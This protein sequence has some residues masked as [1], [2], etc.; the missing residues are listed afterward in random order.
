M[1]HITG[2]QPWLKTSLVNG[3]LAAMYIH[4]GV[5]NIHKIIILGA[6]HGSLPTNKFIFDSLLNVEIKCKIFSLPIELYKRE[7]IQ[8]KRASVTKSPND[9]AIGVATLSGLM[10]IRLEHSI[11]KTMT[12]PS[13][14]LAIDAVTNEL[15]HKSKP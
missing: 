14:K 13:R 11:T 6:I 8:D 1:A 7:A 15:A 10:F 4:K 2:D 3:F 9:A 12:I 5:I